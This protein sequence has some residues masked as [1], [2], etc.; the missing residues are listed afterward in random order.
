[1]NLTE[2]IC[3]LCVKRT[4]IVVPQES[5]AIFS[6]LPNIL[7]NS[8]SGLQLF[9]VTSKNLNVC[10]PCLG[11]IVEL[12]EYKNQIN[13]FC[14]SQSQCSLCKSI[15][16][17]VDIKDWTHFD[18]LLQ[19]IQAKRKNRCSVCIRCISSLDLLETMKVNFFKEYPQLSHHDAAPSKKIISIKNSDTPERKFSKK[20][21]VRYSSQ[22]NLESDSKQLNELKLKNNLKNLKSLNQSNINI[23]DKLKW[24]DKL[25]NQIVSVNI[26]GLTPLKDCKSRK[27][28]NGSLKRNSFRE[29]TSRHSYFKIKLKSKI[30]RGKVKKLKPKSQNLLLNRKELIVNLRKLD[31]STLNH[32]ESPT[33]ASLD[34][35]LSGDS[36]SSSRK[37]DKHVSFSSDLLEEGNILKK[38]SGNGSPLKSVLKKNFNEVN[39]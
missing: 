31:I 10:P 35:L 38:N 27:R 16:Y 30:T 22:F 18:N 19:N 4:K 13:D 3:F 11:H 29:F 9:E 37:S 17:L 28:K 34:M 12:A 24:D 32:I 21:S 36:Y 2:G 1:M 39:P 23:D 33:K 25:L 5:A 14:E 20:I 15:K 8:V 6:F 7:P 26:N